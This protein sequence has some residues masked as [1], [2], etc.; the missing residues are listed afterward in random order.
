MTVALS[1]LT[2][3]AWTAF[4]YWIVPISRSVDPYVASFVMLLANG[5]CTIPLALALDGVP[6]RGDLRPLGFAVLAGVFEV[7]RLRVLLP[8]ARAGDLAVVAP[9][10]GL[11][12]GI[13]ALVVIVFGE[14][15]SVLIARRA[16][17]RARRRLP[18][19]GR[20]AGAAPLRARCRRPAPPSAS[21]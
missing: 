17:D 18:G 10:I 21:G 3:F 4:N 16:R 7:A 20:R 6:G 5:L 14:R 15:V 11:E 2:A 19:R 1:L 9:I 13:A 8:R 12:G